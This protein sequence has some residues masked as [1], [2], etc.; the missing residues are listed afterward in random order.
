MYCLP[1]RS[2][3][4]GFSA[5]EFADFCRDQNIELSLP[6]ETEPWAHGLVESAMRELK[7][8]ASAIQLDILAQDPTGISCFST[9]LHRVCSWF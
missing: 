8:T 2:S 3:S 7:H 6:A 9:Q 4:M 1:L 5:K